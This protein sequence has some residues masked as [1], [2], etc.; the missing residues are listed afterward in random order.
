MFRFRYGIASLELIK[1]DYSGFTTIKDSQ[2][3]DILN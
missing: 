3:K 1:S 2:S